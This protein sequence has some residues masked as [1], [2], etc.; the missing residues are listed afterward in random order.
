MFNLGLSVKAEAAF[1]WWLENR[2]VLMYLVQ[3]SLFFL[4]NSIRFFDAHKP[5]QK[6][7]N[8]SV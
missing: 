7:F 2:H 4:Y 6:T 5:N 8:E 3:S 1:E